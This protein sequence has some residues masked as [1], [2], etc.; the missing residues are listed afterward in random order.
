LDLTEFNEI[1]VTKRCLLHIGMAKTGTSSIQESLKG[2]ADSDWI[3][4]TEERRRPNHIVAFTDIAAAA[5]NAGTVKSRN[6]AT[7]D[8]LVQSLG[9]RT[10]LMSSEGILKLPI[11]DLRN[12]RAYA[13]KQG[14]GDTKIVAYVRSPIEYLT[15]LARAKMGGMLTTLNLKNTKTRYRERFENFDLVFGRENVE[16]WKFDS[17]TFVRGCVVQ[18]FCARIGVNFP[19][20][21]VIR[22]NESLS[23]EA[24]GLFYIYRKYA[25][26]GALEKT[27]TGPGRL[28]LVNQLARIGQKKLRFAP[29]LA[30]P[31]LDNN[32][33]D[34][35]W[36]EER[37]GQPLADRLGEPQADD[38]RSEQDLLRTDPATVEELRTL[39]G[40]AAPQGIRGETPEEI[41]TLVAAL[42]HVEKPAARRVAAEQ[43]GLIRSMLA[44]INRTFATTDND[45]AN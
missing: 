38:I 35:A 3:W 16:L 13:Q 25:D 36:M 28:R 19:A 45:R 11:D 32:R 7:F 10:L 1:A 9:R 44:R 37:L 39:L 34:I 29:E 22:A 27:S 26:P 31:V 30:A 8:T 18:D 42:W 40:A 20:D 6:V 2:F 5:T 41:A 17:R 43:P 24:V 12:F 23:R 4:L 33:A 15:S 21:K 14:I